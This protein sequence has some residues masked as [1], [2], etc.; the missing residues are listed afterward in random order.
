MSSDYFYTFLATAMFATD[1]SVFLLSLV[2]E[3]VYAPGYRMSFILLFVSQVTNSKKKSIW[4]IKEYH[5]LSFLSLF[6]RL[7]FLPLSNIYRNTV[8]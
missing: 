3:I 2:C 7:M 5:Y 8:K 6:Q 1:S 4:K